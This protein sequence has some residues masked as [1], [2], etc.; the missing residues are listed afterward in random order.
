MLLERKYQELR[1][2]QTG[3]LTSKKRVGHPS[4]EHLDRQPQLI[5]FVKPTYL[6]TND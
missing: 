6:W 4:F 2:I 5:G 1:G 3:T